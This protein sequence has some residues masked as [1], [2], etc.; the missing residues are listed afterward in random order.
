MIEDNK[1]IKG[2]N[3]MVGTVKK[4]IPQ[5]TESRGEAWPLLFLLPDTFCVEGELTSNGYQLTSQRGSV[6]EEGRDKDQCIKEWPLA[7]I[8]EIRGAAERDSGSFS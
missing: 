8:A 5:E 2:L 7:R 1:D 4:S 3:R 6:S